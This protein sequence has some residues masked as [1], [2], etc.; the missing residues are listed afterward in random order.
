MDLSFF[1]DTDKQEIDFIEEAARRGTSVMKVAS[2]F[3]ASCSILNNAEKWGKIDYDFLSSS[4]K[5][6]SVDL[7]GDDNSFLA[8]MAV[9]VATSCQFPVSTTYFHAIGV[10]ASAMTLN[11]SY[12]IKRGQSYPC[13][14]YAVSSQPPGSGKSPVHGNFFDPLL[15]ILQ[16]FNKDRAKRSASLKRKAALLADDLKKSKNPDEIDAMISDLDDLNMQIAKLHSVSIETNSTPAAA[17]ASAASQGGFFGIVSDEAEA[18]NV[19]IGATYSSQDASSDFEIFLQGWNGGYFKSN[20][21]SRNGYEGRVRASICVC[22]QDNVVMQLIKTIDCGRGVFDRVLIFLEPDI[23]G[24]RDW[25][26]AM[27][28]EVID[29]RVTDQYRS[30]LT[31]LINSEKRTFTF[32]ESA[33]RLIAHIQNQF[34][35]HLKRGQIYGSD[36]WRGTVSKAAA[37]ICKLACVFYAIDNVR[38]GH[39]Y[40][41]EIGE[42]YIKKAATYYKKV[43]DQMF[44]Q[45]NQHT[46][47]SGDEELRAVYEWLLNQKRK[48]KTG[49]KLMAVDYKVLYDRIRNR[50]CFASVKDDKREYIENTVIPKAEAANLLVMSRGMIYVNPNLMAVEND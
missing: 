24:S 30:M 49:R 2:E 26:K 14:L 33:K 36:A 41:M 4:F 7:I 43:F 48:Q 18:V 50:K 37:Q 45:V 32:S 12:E 15:D 17:D 22:A 40:A 46:G 34:E 11:Y 39:G 9:N 13:N 20:R 1:K 29:K 28:T 47:A 31:E 42:Q 5:R 6:S 21:I 25:S 10:V 23:M 38:A 44:S 27:M 16:S 19:M 3:D 8:E 35:P